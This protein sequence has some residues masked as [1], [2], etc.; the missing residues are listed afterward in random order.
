[1]KSVVAV[2]E[3]ACGTMGSSFK[4]GIKCRYLAWVGDKTKEPT[5][6]SVSKAKADA[7]KRKTVMGYE[8]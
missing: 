6:Y 5:L 3:I 4:L 7:A 8:M 2:K 1:M